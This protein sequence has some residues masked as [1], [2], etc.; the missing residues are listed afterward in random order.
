VDT[1]EFSLRCGRRSGD[2]GWSV[3]GIG[4][5]W[6]DTV[7]PPGGA[8]ATMEM[9]CFDFRAPLRADG[10]LNGF[11]CPRKR[12]AMHD[13]WSRTLVGLVEGLHFSRRDTGKNEATAVCGGSALQPLRYRHR[14]AGGRVNSGDIGLRPLNAKAIRN[15]KGGRARPRTRCALG[16]LIADRDSYKAA[17]GGQCVP[18]HR[19]RSEVSSFQREGE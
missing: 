7:C 5:A 10:G 13:I 18:H 3:S 19:K 9:T 16:P 4:S 1:V 6:G 17:G 2:E 11:I 8:A 15:V 12:S 14:S